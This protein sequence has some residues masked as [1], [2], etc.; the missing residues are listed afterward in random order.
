M[1]AEQDMQDSPQARGETVLTPHDAPRAPASPRQ[2]ADSQPHARLYTGGACA[3]RFDAWRELAADCQRRWLSADPAWLS[4][5]S[6]SMRH[7]PYVVEARR[8]D[9]LTGVLPLAFVRSRL[10]GRRLVSLPYLNTAGL[11]ARDS[12]SEQALL[13]RAIELAHDLNVRYLELRHERNVEHPRLTHLTGH[14]AHMRLDLPPTAGELWD[15]LRAK[16]RNQVRKGRDHKL[17]VAW[18]GAELLDEFY[19][20][21]S[22][23]MRDLGTP[24]Y[25]RRFFGAILAQFPG[26]AELCVVRLG[27][28]PIAA[29]LLTHGAGVTEV[30]S[31]SSLRKFNGTSANMLMYWS[32]LCRAVERGQSVFDFGRSSPES[33]PYRFKKQWGAQPVEAV[34][35]YYAPGGQGVERLRLERGSYSRAVRLWRRLPLWLTLLIGPRIVRGIP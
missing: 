11:V 2:P 34:W 22:R 15:A 35:Q 17:D 32:L 18:S 9:Q 24:V 20:V 33:G 29:A 30:P 7:E 1:P 16:V 23:N 27:Q 19:A 10:F 21:F 26:A 8:G 28:R 3:A 14:R 6:E 25:S 13:D 12:H 31:A 5:L 4:V